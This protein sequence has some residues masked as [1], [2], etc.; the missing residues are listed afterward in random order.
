MPNESDLRK[1]ETGPRDLN[2]GKCNYSI[3]LISDSAAFDFG[4]LEQSEDLDMSSILQ[5]I[6]ILFELTCISK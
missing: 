4:C 2:F 1:P 3:A 5:R 6:P